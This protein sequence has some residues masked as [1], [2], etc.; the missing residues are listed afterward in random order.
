MLMD[1]ALRIAE[2]LRY[3]KTVEEYE[4]KHG[5]GGAKPHERGPERTPPETRDKAASKIDERTKE[6]EGQ[7]EDRRTPERSR[8]PRND[9]TQM[10][11]GYGIAIVAVADAVNIMPGKW[12]AVL[13]GFVGAAVA[14]VA[15]AN[16]RWKEKHGHRPED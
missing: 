8:L 7:R 5:V 12:D 15:W 14:T 6:L 1:P 9:T 4:A 2:A 10:V 11:A 3:R 16:R 13:T